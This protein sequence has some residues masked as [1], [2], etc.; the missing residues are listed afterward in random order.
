MLRLH[1]S[2]WFG[3]GMLIFAIALATYWIPTWV[4]TPEHVRVIVLSPDFWPYIVAAL[5]A[6]GGSTLL[7][8][9]YFFTRQ[10]IVA[11]DDNRV[12]GGNM[13]IALVA[14]LMAAYYLIMP[15]I[16][17]VLSSML[18]YIAFMAI[19]RL[20]RLV[21]SVIIAIALPLLLYAFFDH[22]AGVPIP[23]PDFLRLP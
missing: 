17:M 5:L 12:A 8:Q 14:I 1:S 4:I 7:A 16:G 21:T 23:Q 15:V 3:G 10:T 18:A 22:V 11:L 2:V 20:P 13:R 9:Y 6:I 19:I